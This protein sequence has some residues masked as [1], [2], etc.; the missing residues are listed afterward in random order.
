MLFSSHEAEELRGSPPVSI[1]YVIDPQVFF[2]RNRNRRLIAPKV[3]RR[4]H[5]LPTQN[6]FVHFYPG[7]K[8][9]FCAEVKW[10][11]ANNVQVIVHVDFA[12]L[13]EEACDHN[14]KSWTLNIARSNGNSPLQLSTSRRL[15]SNAAASSSTA[16]FAIT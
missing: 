10:I 1:P 4:R 2:I 15:L 14:F 9:Q 13:H 8:P 16:F 3:A 12:M 7:T 6:S 11:N 5:R